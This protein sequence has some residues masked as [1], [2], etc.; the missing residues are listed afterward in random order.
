MGYM[1]THPGKKLLFMGNE[2]APYSEWAFNKSLD[3]HLLKYPSHDSAYHYMQDLTNLYKNSRCL[4]ELDYSTEGF[5]YIDADNADQSLYIYAR[6]AKNKDDHYLIVMNCTPN[7]YFDYKI[8]VPGKYDYI[9]ILNSDKDIY[10]GSNN[11]NPEVRKSQ[12]EDWK[13]EKNVIFLNIPPL[14]ITILKARKKAAPKRTQPKISP[15]V[16]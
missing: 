11:I 7:S 10:G 8:G 5:R 15:I 12:E 4:Y 1:M 9:E 6:F 13:H 16:K 3:W 14:G 2:L